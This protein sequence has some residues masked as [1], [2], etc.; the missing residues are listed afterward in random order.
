VRFAEWQVGGHDQRS[1]FVP[2]ADDLEDELGRAVRQGEI[3][4]FI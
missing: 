3:P 4:Q 1:A 2:L